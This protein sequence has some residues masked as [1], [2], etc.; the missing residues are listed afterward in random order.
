MISRMAGL[1]GILYSK[2]YE[3]YFIIKYARILSV[4]CLLLTY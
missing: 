3:L 1:C 4:I 2:V